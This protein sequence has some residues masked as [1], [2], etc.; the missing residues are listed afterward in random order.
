M[1]L[2]KIKN[3]STSILDTISR[4]RDNR[5]P[6]K[7]FLV[8]L[9]KGDVCAPTEGY[10]LKDQQAF[11]PILTAFSSLTQGH[12]RISRWDLYV[13]YKSWHE[14]RGVTY[15]PLSSKDFMNQFVEAIDPSQWGGKYAVIDDDTLTSYKIYDIKNKSITKKGKGIQ[16]DNVRNMAY[17][18]FTEILRSKSEYDSIIKNLEGVMDEVDTSMMSDDDFNNDI[19]AKISN[20]LDLSNSIV[21]D[22]DEEKRI[23]QILQEALQKIKQGLKRD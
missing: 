19:T 15:K 4:S 7:Q 3:E 18:F 20:I 8:A 5:E 16:I 11:D 1:E 9:C 2:H 13:L 21:G 12:I 10:Q 6:A 14:S 22:G 17:Y 23:N